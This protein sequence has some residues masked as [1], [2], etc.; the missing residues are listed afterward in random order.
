MWTRLLFIAGRWGV[1]I[2]DPYLREDETVNSTHPPTHELGKEFHYARHCCMH[3][4]EGP[5][6]VGFSRGGTRVTRT[7]LAHAWTD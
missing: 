5:C 6:V 1:E 2:L 4:T 3:G 7:V